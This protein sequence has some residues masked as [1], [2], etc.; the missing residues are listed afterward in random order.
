MTDDIPKDASILRCWVKK[1]W[2]TSKKVGLWFG[3][4]AVA[5]IAAYVTWLGLTSETAE[6]IWLAATGWFSS[7]IAGISN[8]ITTIPPVVFWGSIAVSTVVVAILGY[9]LAWCM[10]RNLTEEDW[11]SDKANA[12]AALT[13]A[14]LILAAPTLAA[15]TLIVLTLIVLT[16]ILT[17]I[18]LTL[19]VLPLAAL[20]VDPVDK[21]TIWYYIFRF[22]GAYLNYR[23]RVK[24]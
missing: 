18:V 23:G 19:I 5:L 2:S 16:P 17:L 7:V 8:Y 1:S 13:L 9:S 20:S 11:K 24:K 6:R 21:I 12:V 4:I 14:A 15:L 3:G 22:I 10:A